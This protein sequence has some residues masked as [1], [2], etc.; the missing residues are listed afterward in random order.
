MKNSILLFL[1]VLLVGGF[2]TSCSKINNDPGEGGGGSNTIILNANKLDGSYYGEEYAAGVGNY[3]IYL[4]D[5][6]FDS[7][8]EYIPNSFYFRIDLFGPISTEQTNIKIPNGAY[9]FD[10][11]NSKEE[12]TFSA[13]YSRYITTNNNG[14]VTEQQFDNAQFTVNGNEINLYVTIN[15]IDYHIKFNKEYSLSDDR[16]NQD[17]PTNDEEHYSTIT[18]DYDVEFN[19]ANARL[20]YAGDW[21]QC[22][23]DNWTI[24]IMS[25]EN[26]IL[27]GDTILLDF[28]T[29]HNGRNE[30][31]TGTYTISDTPGPMILM[32]GSV[33]YSQPIGS[34]YF[35]Y[36]SA[37]IVGQA[38]FTSGT[39]NI[40][41][42][43]S[44]TYTFILDAYDD[45]V[46]KNRVTAQWTGEITI[47]S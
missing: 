8:D 2:L 36:R 26:D 17:P 12:F 33:L 21:W 34:W 32:R 45:A 38:A 31:I 13:Q 43:S 44:G 19:N 15:N 47:A 4:S 30:D 6:G 41:K 24:Y 42:N 14:S 18:Q 10:K 5:N 23:Y 46:N 22:G 40:T 1:S 29:K 16:V 20:D 35:D 28:I 37:S 11:N 39:L 25:K 7:N 9:T 3:W 27:N